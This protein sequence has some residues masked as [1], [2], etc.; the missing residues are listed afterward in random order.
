VEGTG[1]KSGVHETFA[2]CLRHRQTPTL[3]QARGR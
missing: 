3:Q 1:L 2:G